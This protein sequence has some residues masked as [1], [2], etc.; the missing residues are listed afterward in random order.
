M[1]HVVP[2]SLAPTIT[3]FLASCANRAN[4][5]VVLYTI[6]VTLKAQTAGDITTP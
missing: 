1:S 5:C 6:N 4:M 3:S 2:S